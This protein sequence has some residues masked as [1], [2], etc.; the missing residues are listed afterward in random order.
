MEKALK[1]VYQSRKAYFKGYQSI[2]KA[3]FLLFISQYQSR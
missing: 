3:T 2:I 1:K